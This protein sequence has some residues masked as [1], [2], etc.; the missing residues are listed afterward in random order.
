ME[1]CFFILKQISAIVKCLC[2]AS[3]EQLTNQKHRTRCAPIATHL[4]TG[5]GQLCQNVSVCRSHH[6]QSHVVWTSNWIGALWLLQ[7][8][9]VEPHKISLSIWQYKFQTCIFGHSPKS[10]V[11]HR[12]NILHSIKADFCQISK[13]L[14]VCIFS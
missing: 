6:Q 7:A 10:D 5:C 13:K 3:E 12:K 2:M 9:T 4:Q 11:T 14:H 1:H 8:Y